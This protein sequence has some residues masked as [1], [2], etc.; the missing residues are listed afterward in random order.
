MSS[1]PLFI[2]PFTTGSGR[3]I[4]RGGLRKGTNGKKKNI[5]VAND[6]AVVAENESWLK[7][8]TKGLEKYVD[9]KDLEMNVEKTK[10]MK[11]RRGKGRWKNIV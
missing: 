6:V 10:M 9:G 3:D 7:E 8:I 2:Y 5:L 4:G 11:C 1:E